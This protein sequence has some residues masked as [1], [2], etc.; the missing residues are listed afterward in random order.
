MSNKIK[1][2]ATQQTVISKLM[3]CVLEYIIESGIE[4]EDA[5]Y[6]FAEALHQIGEQIFLGAQTG[7][8]ESWIE[9][10]KEIMSEYGDLI[11]GLN[12]SELTPHKKNMSV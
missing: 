2:I 3:E 5:P 9:S 8:L 6:V 11:E 7:T 10:G 1:S 4:S 12:L